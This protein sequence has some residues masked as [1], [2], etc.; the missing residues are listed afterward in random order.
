MVNNTAVKLE[1][2]KNTKMLGD[3][4]LANFTMIAEN[5]T[6]QCVFK[7]TKLTTLVSFYFCF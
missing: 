5:V 6:D 1:M 7:E 4:H 3:G 2:E